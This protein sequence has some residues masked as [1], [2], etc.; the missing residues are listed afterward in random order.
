[1]I[2]YL[3]NQTIVTNLDYSTIDKIIKVFEKTFKKLGKVVN[4]ES[5]L[6]TS[7]CWRVILKNKSREFV[8][9]KIYIN[10][11]TNYTLKIKNTNSL[12]E[13]NGLKLEKEVNQ[14]L[15]TLV[16]KFD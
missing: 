9:F 1:M 7:M 4:V 6:L 15:K 2:S 3:A 16:I 11:P 12:D 8:T 13:K 14:I 5:N 10:T